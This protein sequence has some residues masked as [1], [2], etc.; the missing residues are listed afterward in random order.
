VTRRTS[1]FLTALWGGLLWCACARADWLNATR[2]QPLKEVAHTVDVRIVDGI[3]T[4]RVRRSFRNAS[5]DTAEEARLFIELPHGA[6]ATGLRIR[7]AGRWYDGELMHAS[8][9]EELYQEL[10]GLGPSR[11]KD[12]A[13][14][15]WSWTDR[16][17]LRV[18][19]IFPGK[20]STVEYTLTAPT[21]YQDGV[22][23]I[24]YGR[25]PEDSNLA[26]PVLRVS[27]P[28]REG[29]LLLDGEPQKG[30]R[31]V[32]GRP[33]PHPILARYG[34]EDDRVLVREMRVEPDI[35]AESV[36]LGIDLKHTW[37]GDMQI[38]L[39]DPDGTLHRVRRHDF[40]QR[41][42]DLRATFR[43]ERSGSL[44]GTWYLLLEDHHPLDGGSLRSW[45]LSPALDGEEP[46]A[47]APTFADRRP[48]FIP[49]PGGDDAGI[50]TV[51]VMLQGNARSTHVRLGR[52]AMIP[53]T[54]FARLEVDMAR[55]L[56]ETP[57]RQS[58]VFVVDASHSMDEEGIDAQLQLARAY[59]SHLPDA[60]FALVGTRRRA[61]LWSDFTP[62][63]SFEHTVSALQAAGRL[64]P[65]NGSFL[66]RG[67]ARAQ[68]LL[69]KQQGPTA[70][71]LLTDDR[72]RP[73]WSTERTLE[74]ADRLPPHSVLHVVDASA[75]GVP[76]L[77]RSDDHRL[78]P[79]A[80]RRGGVAVMAHGLAGKRSQL[81]REALYLVRPNRLDHPGLDNLP[82]RALQVSDNIDFI[83][84]GASLRWMDQVKQAPQSVT[85]K[86]Q[87]WSRPA[88]FIAVTGE[89]FHRATAAYV[90]S[91]DHYDALTPAQ[92]FV[93]ASYG[94]AVSPVTSYLAI[95]PGVRPS[96]IG[97]EDRLGTVGHGRGAG[98]FRGRSAHVPRP[99]DWDAIAE[100][101]RQRCKAHPSPTRARA[102][103]DT[104]DH[105]IVDVR[106]RSK[107]D[108]HGR[109]VVEALWQEQLPPGTRGDVSRTLVL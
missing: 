96:T 1:I 43:V 2:A 41:Q 81:E 63:A 79:L 64:A 91:L 18:F 16:L 52:V 71:I 67:L 85:L 58:V 106:L 32:L 92:Q 22:H 103:V 11:P 46:R 94:R 55:R 48:A 93:V 37:P 8:R 82:E 77:L 15:Y 13:L 57:Q 10:T 51:G 6:A 17:G 24:S 12:P 60:R 27:G 109:C 34:I 97:L 76:E 54:Q 78:F 72:L 36:A 73:A 104:T 38:D 70:V 39:V 86:G 101:A 35:Q 50:A 47:G 44:R 45:S 53:G 69:S 99:I 7:A 95:E 49:Q 20:T 14:L 66:D 19:P 87:L 98:G 65:N 26:T 62:A 30:A 3:A 83:R 107:D 89:P 25:Q 21:S 42:N 61:E 40:S 105:E 108:D 88:E 29:R 5:R 9:A 80:Q 84:E 4:Y 102:R 100:R 68:Q 28:G 59:L 74:D 33:R 90:F 56:S 75:R 23:Y 31:V